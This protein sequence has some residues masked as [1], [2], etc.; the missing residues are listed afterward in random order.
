MDPSPHSTPNFGLKKAAVKQRLFLASFAFTSSSNN[1]RII[2]IHSIFHIYR[3]HFDIAV[4]TCCQTKPSVYLCLI[5]AKCLTDPHLYLLTLYHIFTS[6]ATLFYRFFYFYIL[7]IYLL[8]LPVNA[9]S[10][11]TF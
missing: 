3:R 8:I 1:S 5:N 9:A 4:S 6:T 7:P 11:F 2:N 10:N